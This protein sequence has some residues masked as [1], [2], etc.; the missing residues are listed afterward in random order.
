MVRQ[1]QGRPR[2]RG[3]GSKPCD[4]KATCANSAGTFTCTC[5]PGYN[6]DGK[7]C[8][9]V[10]ECK[11]GSAVCD[12]AAD[13]TNTV[14]GYG[15]ACKAGYKGDGKTC[16]DVDECK[17]GIGVGILPTPQ[18]LAGWT[19]VNSSKVVGCYGAGDKLIYNSPVQ[20]DYATGSDSNKGSAATPLLK[21]PSLGVTS[22]S[23]VATLEVESGT[24]FDTFAVSVIEAGKSPTVIS[25]KVAIGHKPG[26]PVLISL[27]KWAGKSIQIEF[28]F[29]TKDGNQNSFFGIVIG[30]L[31]LETTACGTNAGCSNSPGTYTCA[32]D[33]GYLGDG[34]VCTDID[35]CKVNKG[36]CDVN[37]DCTNLPGS[38]QCVCKTYWTGDGKTCAD[39]DECKTNNG[40][41][42]LPEA[43][44]CTNNVGAKPTCADVDECKAGTA[45]C[46]AQ[47]TCANTKGSYA[48]TC[49]AGYLGDGK[50]C[51]DVDECK[52]G[53]LKAQAS[54]ILISTAKFENSHPKAGWRLSD[55]KLIYNNPD[56]GNYNVS[57]AYKGS[58]TTAAIALPVNATL[59]FDGVFD[60]ETTSDYD[61]FRVEL[62]IGSEA[63]VV[64]DK[65]KVKLGKTLQS[66]AIALGA[67][68]GK[69]AQIRFVFDTVDATA[70]GTSGIALSNFGMTFLVPACGANAACTNAPGTYACACSP[71]FAG[72]GQLCT[73]IDECKP[74][75]VPMVLPA[76]LA[77]WKT[78]T[79]APNQVF[80][81]VFNNQ[82]VFSN[83]ATSTYEVPSFA[84]VGTATS[85]VVKLP[86]NPVELS[87][88]LKLLVE[89]LPSVDKFSVE[90]LVG[91]QVVKTWSKADFKGSAAGITFV[92]PLVGLGG[93][94]VQLWFTLDSVDSGFNNFAGPFVSDVKFRQLEPCSK[95]ATCANSP[96]AFA[97]TCNSGYQGDGKTCADIDECKIDNGGCSADATC[98]NKDG[99]P[100]VCACKPGYTGDGKTCA[101]IDECKTSNGGCSADATCTNKVGAP[102]VCACKP[103]YAGDG[104]TC[105][106]ID[107][108][109]TNNGGCSVNAN[110]TNKVAAPVVCACKPGY[111]G[112]GK[113]CALNGNY[114]NTKCGQGGGPGGCFCDGECKGYGDCCSGPSNV[115]ASK[116]ADSTCG[117]CQ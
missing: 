39:I 5:K 87:F 75:T 18:G 36:G 14:G 28:A 107:E 62:L 83:P 23:F 15:C 25:T 84:V 50:T 91:A 89:P 20:G 13:C 74:T 93:K 68:A 8:A 71:G 78:T 19:V 55:G 72:D 106:D 115:K 60:V 70:N 54:D 4:A 63:L 34:Q 97:C 92:A 110:C 43:N 69:T 12:L 90:V 114:C 45:K 98:T 42:G 9:D 22:L 2:R 88:N 94:E 79:S 32:C 99:A 1:W 113:T 82:L 3:D 81:R 56:T 101:D 47:A 17:D 57:V 59:T 116:C 104:K 7:T 53:A 58:V 11:D 48:C 111:T 95:V 24:F 26:T 105:A 40:A 73:D 37:A 35:E 52:S 31:A 67:H 117:V 51:T 112:D 102:V 16:A 100:V 65:S 6:G 41:C 64:F 108:C 38:S 21:V 49:N 44:T 66:I 27:A 77:G 30:K 85:P 29:D 80:W 61:K 96:G 46:A 103:G 33:K 76:D 10:D 109:K 86:G